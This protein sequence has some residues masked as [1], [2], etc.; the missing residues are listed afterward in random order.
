MNEPYAEHDESNLAECNYEKPKSYYMRNIDPVFWRK[1]KHLA[2]SMDLSVNALIK[3]LLEQ[4]VERSE[5]FD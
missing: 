4:A 1:V 3:T 5:L 2:C